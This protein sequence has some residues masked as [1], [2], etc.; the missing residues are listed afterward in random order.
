MM[1]NPSRERV[2]NK[3]D[4]ALLD[5]A[6][7]LHL[8]DRV[9]PIPGNLAQSLLGL[10]PDTFKVLETEIDAI[11]HNGA[12][13]NLVKLYAALNSV[14]VLRTLEVLRLAVTNGLAK[15]RVKP[16]HYISTGA[17]FPS[18]YSAP[19]FMEVADLSKV[20]DQLDNGYAQSK[21]VGV[22]ENL[23][24]SRPT[25]PPSVNFASV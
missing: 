2:Q 21:Q 3:I 25:W 15:T 8:E 1:Q 12:D 6:Q 16:V 11:V 13:V 14:N 18:T 24:R 17:I 7:K 23:P 5:E 10:P 22:R 19:K 20:S 9:V 4:F